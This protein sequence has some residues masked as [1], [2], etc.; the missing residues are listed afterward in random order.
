MK[1]FNDN[2]M[3][4][5]SMGINVADYRLKIF[6]ITAVMASLAGSI[7]VSGFVSSCAALRV[8]TACGTYHHDHYRRR[9]DLYGPLL[10]AFIVMWMQELNPYVSGQSPPRDDR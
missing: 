4:S 7:S 6:V 9:K 8:S 1:S 5:M 2:E 10:G 3:A